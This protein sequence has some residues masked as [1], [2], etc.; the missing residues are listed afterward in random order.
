MEEDIVSS[1]RD[2]AAS[3]L[4]EGD[5]RTRMQHCRRAIGLGRQAVKSAE[6]MSG[7][8]LL[9]VQDTLRLA[10]RASRGTYNPNASITKL[11][12]LRMVYVNC[13]D[14][15]DMTTPFGGF[16]ESGFGRDQ[17]L[18]AL[19]KVAKIEG[20]EHLKLVPKFRRT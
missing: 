6:G 13:Y 8:E 5:A 9:E 12:K 10:F 19:D 7:T 2:L 4:S 1:C 20:G 18:H 15:D 14:C 16:K 11:A 17:S 3:I